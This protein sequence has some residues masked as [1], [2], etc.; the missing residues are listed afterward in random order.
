MILEKL[1]EVAGALLNKL[2]DKQDTKKAL[3]FLEKKIN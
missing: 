3:L 2:A 1:D